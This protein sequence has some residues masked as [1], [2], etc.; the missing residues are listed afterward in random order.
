MTPESPTNLDLMCYDFVELCSSDLA[1]NSDITASETRES[2][3]D[4]IFASTSFNSL[5]KSLISIAQ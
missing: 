4:R 2:E 3:K 1:A 5:S